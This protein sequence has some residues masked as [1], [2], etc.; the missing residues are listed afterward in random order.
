MSRKR[1]Q[2]DQTFPLSQRK[3]DVMKVRRTPIRRKEAKGILE[4]ASK[5]GVEASTDEFKLAET[6]Q[7]GEY[8]V[9][10]LD[11]VPILIITSSGE[12]VPHL[13][14]YG[15]RVRCP[16]VT[17]DDRAAPHIIGGADVMAPGVVSTDEFKGGGAVVALNSA[18][19]ALSSGIAVLSS[20]EI[21]QVNK[22]RAVRTVHVV[23]DQIWKLTEGL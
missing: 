8:T 22:G 15:K 17:V 2:K 19:R 16:Q 5:F 10:L 7:Q 9:L 14:T 20:D 13:Q 3:R 4:E 23:G 21:K 11:K 18:G 12:I 6:I 1:S